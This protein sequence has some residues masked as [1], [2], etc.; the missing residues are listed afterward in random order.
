MLQEDYIVIGLYCAISDKLGEQDKR[1][2]QGKLFLSE[3]LLCGVLF[4]LKGGSFRQFYIW[5]KR[6]NLFCL[7]ERTR[8]ERLLITHHGKCNAFLADP[9]L[10]NVMDSYGVEVIHPIR[11][12]RSKQSQ[13]VSKKG[14]SNHRWIV[15][16]KINVAINGKL[17]IVKVDHASA[18]VHDNNFNDQFSKI[19]GIILTDFGFRQKEGTPENFKLCKRGTWGER[20]G[21][22]QLFSLWTRVCGMKHSFHRTVEG[23]AAKALFLC[24]LTNL[25]FDLNKVFDFPRFSM[26]QWSL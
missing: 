20:M 19:E 24:A 21:V 14:K 25:I 10:F 3:I 15:G 12:N 26:V 11:E 1:H 17:S 9:T 16:R 18:N 23:F 22:E 8:L 4:A 7:P 6:R 2:K 13:S 5:L